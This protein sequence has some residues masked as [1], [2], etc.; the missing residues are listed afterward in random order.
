MK[1]AFYWPIFLGPL[2]KQA[3]FWGLLEPL[4]EGR[5]ERLLG[6]VPEM[7]L[8][9]AHRETIGRNDAIDQDQ[10]AR[11]FGI[12]LPESLLFERPWG[13]LCPVGAFARWYLGFSADD[14]AVLHVPETVE[15]QDRLD[16][17]ASQQTEADRHLWVAVQAG[18]EDAR[19]EFADRVEYLGDTGR[20]GLLRGGLRRR[21][22]TLDDAWPSFDREP[23][24]KPRNVGR[25]RSQAAYEQGSNMLFDVTKSLDLLSG[26]DSEFEA[27]LTEGGDDHQR[28]GSSTG[29]LGG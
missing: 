24:L 18:D 9:R 20:A 2:G 14:V 28:S 5:I 1:T 25:G 15:Y 17:L 12:H 10:A 3:D 29:Q 27:L 8:Y 23:N 11:H 7:F 26:R 4:D 16:A 22:R 21:I 6:R 13:M 19:R